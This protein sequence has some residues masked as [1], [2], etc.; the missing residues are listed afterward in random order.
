VVALPGFAR[1]RF[2]AFNDIN[3]P[4]AKIKDLELARYV[5]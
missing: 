1:G 4:L 2:V 5:R 3:V